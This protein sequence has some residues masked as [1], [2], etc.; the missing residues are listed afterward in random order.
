MTDNIELYEKKYPEKW[1][2]MQNTITQAFRDM[3]I[4]EKRLIILAST[5]VR[6]TEATEQ[7]PIEVLASEFHKFSGVDEKSAYKQM[8]LAS[9]KLMK[10]SFVYDDK[11]GVETEVQWVIRSKY[12][13]GFV[14]IFF[15]N[16]VIQ[17]LKVFDSVNPYT[18]YLKDDVLALR[19]TYSI[20]LYHLAKKYQ[21]MGGF[22]ISLDDYRKE[23]GTPK[24]YNRINNLKDNAVDPVIKEINDKTDL[25]IS[26]ENIKRGKEVTGLKFTVKSKPKPKIKDVKAVEVDKY[27]VDKLN[28][29]QL[30]AIVCTEAFKADYNHMISATSPINTDWTLWQPEMVKRLKANP[31]KFIKRSMQFYLSQISKYKNKA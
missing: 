14:T 17:L 22:K 26:Y 23:L 20:D 4:D 28:D 19:L 30:E 10:R 13:D 25:N 3:S 11:N 2:V 6:L 27:S 9:K 18:K 8:K 16:E 7:K 15:T 24:S 1:I 21:G 12:N 29:K 5:L 31:E